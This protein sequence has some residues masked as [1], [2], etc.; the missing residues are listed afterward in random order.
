[1]RLWVVDEIEKKCM[2]SRKIT[3]LDT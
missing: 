1:V 2:C 3:W